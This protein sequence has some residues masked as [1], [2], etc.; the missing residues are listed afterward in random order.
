MSFENAREFF[1][2]SQSLMFSPH[3]RC[4]SCDQQQKLTL[5]IIHQ[6]H[7]RNESKNPI[8]YFHYSKMKQ[9]NIY[10]Q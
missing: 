7:Q 6:P 2:F 8:P 3:P 5:K 1:D 10:N 4:W 9:T